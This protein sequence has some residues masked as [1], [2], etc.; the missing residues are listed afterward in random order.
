[1][2]KNEREILKEFLNKKDFPKIFY[3]EGNEEIVFFDSII[4]GLC[5][6]LLSSSRIK[7]I[8]NVPLLDDEIDTIIKNNIDK[9]GVLEYKTLLFETIKIIENILKNNVTI[10]IITNFC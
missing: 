4:A 3:L 10:K 9:E 6:R 5:S 1:M 8:V 2:K 7:N